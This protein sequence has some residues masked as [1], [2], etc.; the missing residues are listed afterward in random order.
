[1]NVSQRERVSIVSCHESFWFP[2]SWTIFLTRI[3]T[4][5]ISIYLAVTQ[6][7]TSSF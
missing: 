1:M 5:P 4:G 3:Q 2:F 6:L 7:T